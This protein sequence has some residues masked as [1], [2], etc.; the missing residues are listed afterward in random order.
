MLDLI[1]SPFFCHIRILSLNSSIVFYGL[2]L[3]TKSLKSSYFLIALL[4][5]RS[6]VQTLYSINKFSGSMCLSPSLTT[7]YI[8]DSLICKEAIYFLPVGVLIYTPNF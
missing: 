4:T 3:I 5:F 1:S 6:L 8:A 2:R 7:V